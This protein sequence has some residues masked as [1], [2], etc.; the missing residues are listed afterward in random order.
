MAKSKSLVWKGK[1]LTEKMRKAQVLGVN[2]TMGA[3]VVQ[4]K[5]NHAFQNRTGILE[6]S[7]DV[8][9]YAHEKD[10]GVEGTWGSKDVKYA[11]AIEQGATIQHPGGTPYFVGEDGRAQF[12]SLDDPRAAGL[13]KTKPH[14]IVI[15]AHPFLRPAADIKYP[16]LPGNIRKAYK[17][18]EK[19]G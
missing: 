14:E 11:R 6:G 19:A 9:T 13:P 1:A 15:P 8:A 4:A 2:A 17:K 7:I 5:E 18:L 12:V 3:C 16:D 10:G